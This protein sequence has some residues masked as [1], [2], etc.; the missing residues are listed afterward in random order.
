MNIKSHIEILLYSIS[1]VIL[2]AGL[3]NTAS[4][5]PGVL[6][7]SFGSGGIVT[8]NVS[9]SDD[10]ILATAI[11]SD[12]KIV[13]AGYSEKPALFTVARYNTNGTLDSTFGTG[14][15]VK[16]SFNNSGFAR[17][18]IIQSDGKIIVGGDAENKFALVRYTSTGQLDTNFGSQ[19]KVLTTIG[20]VSAIYGLSVQSDGKII[21]AG[22]TEKL[23]DFAIVRYTSN[24][25]LDT[26]FGGGDGIVTTDFAND[27][28]R[29][30]SIKLQSD[31][32]ILV[33]GSSVDLD[34]NTTFALT[35]YN[36]DGTLDEN[37]NGSGKVT[38]VTSC[39][40]EA[41][42]IQSDGKIVVTG[43]F[44]DI[45]LA[46]YTTSGDLDTTFGS[47]GIVTTNIGGNYDNAYDLVIDAAG[48]ILVAGS[49][50]SS[51]NEDMIVARY[52]SNGSLDA[53]FDN[54]DGIAIISLSSQSDIANSIALQ[55]NGGII[56]G[57]SKGEFG[58]KEFATI[59][60]IGYQPTAADAVIS[61]RVTSGP[62]GVSQVRVALTNNQGNTI[63]AMTNFLGYYYFYNQ[64][65]GQTYILSAHHN[66]YSFTPSSLAVNLTGD[67]SSANFAV[68]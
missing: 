39:G 23:A 27:D 11:Q 41:L 45:Y 24:G 38:T 37:F 4:A 63:Y 2:L 35:R 9:T 46:R 17:A 20:N 68:Q 6:D 55:S 57:G 67:Y 25:G 40:A 49:T 15:I 48:K 21:A 19:G 7:T 16:T 54:G 51:G 28:D 43:A 8:T 31:G 26:A 61:G 30:T 14:G 65:V 53:S 10:Q 32:R 56:A 29:A 13:T 44:D 47:G 34:L 22:F 58:A 33:A 59:K 52:Q 3:T 50:V 42:G 18:I 66:L 36:T 62:K 12:N 64:Q 1:L 5:Q 60:L